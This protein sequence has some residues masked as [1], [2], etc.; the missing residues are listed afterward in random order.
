MINWKENYWIKDSGEEGAWGEWSRF[1]PFPFGW[2]K[3]KE[4]T[5]SEHW[6]HD[7][8]IYYIN[9]FRYDGFGIRV[10]KIP[11][12]QWTLSV[13]KLSNSRLA[14]GKDYVIEDCN[15]V[16]SSDS[17]EVIFQEAYD[18]MKRHKGGENK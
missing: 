11:N 8:G 17:K 14:E 18:F 10:E 12:K 13:G 16:N 1:L 7:E 2:R 4:Y 3:A 15:K 6:G 9:F 5:V